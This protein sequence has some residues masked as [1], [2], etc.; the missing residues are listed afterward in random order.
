M[1]PAKPASI[2]IWASGADLAARRYWGAPCW[3]WAMDSGMSLSQPSEAMDEFA[4]DDVGGE[5]GG[6]G[7]GLGVEEDDLGAFEDCLGVA[8]GVGLAL[9]SSALFMPS[10]EDRSLPPAVWVTL[11]LRSHCSEAAGVGPLD[12]A[13]GIPDRS[14]RQRARDSGGGGLD[15]RPRTFHAVGAAADG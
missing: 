11:L 8:E 2:H 5:V 10:P 4:V 14:S 1:P 7:T 6:V 3:Y 9:Q 15:H 12:P 13:P